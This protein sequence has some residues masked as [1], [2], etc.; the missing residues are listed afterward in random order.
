MEF[1]KTFL[2][3]FIRGFMSLFC[4]VPLKKNKVTFFSYNGTYYCNLK[5]ISEYISSNKDIDI[6]WI[7][8]PN[9]IKVPNVT[10]YKKN[11][12]MAIYSI[13]T[14]KVVVFN[15]GI[16]NYMFK[17]ASQFYIETWHGGGAYKKIA[18]AFS[19]EKD[20]FLRKR[21]VS[22][23]NRPDYIIASC[24]AFEK[25][26]KEDTMAVKPAYCHFG[27]PRNDIFF[28]IKKSSIVKE[29]ILNKYCL[30][31][32]KIAIYAPTFREGEFK[33]SIDFKRLLKA[34]GDRFCGDF[35]LFLRC[36][37][38]IKSD[39]FN[40]Y[41]ESIDIID[42][43]SYPDMQ[44]LLCASD[45]L[46]TDYS[47]SMWDFSLSYKLCLV[48]APDIEDYRQER[49]FHTPI[50]EWPFPVATNNDEL[51]KNIM[52]FDYDIYVNNIRKHHK[53]LGS[54]EDGHASEKVGKMIL[55][56]CK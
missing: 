3:F 55:E 39:V 36:H 41:S 56:L 28:S 6:V 15:N 12:L 42:V 21:R 26:Y 37:P 16:M 32:K 40:N 46:I 48:Y 31:G 54:Y 17:R 20:C 10:V 27:M 5:Y 45:V 18:R 33:S 25:A 24:A 7:G 35:V 52:S 11:S 13:F 30:G 43:S 29:N 34:L 4:F 47:S 19:G 50:S 53:E 49:D 44:E 23:A 1:I 14:A 51:E 38:H 8:D 22:S 9:S 2:S